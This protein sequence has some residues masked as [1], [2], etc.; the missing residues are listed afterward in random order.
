[1]A[2]GR[3]V[4]PLLDW[5]AIEALPEYRELEDSRRRFAWR[6]GA[7]GVG[8]GALYVVLAGVAPGLMGTEVLGSI[9]L[10]FVGGIGLIL[11]T[12]AITFAYMRRSDRVWGPMEEQVRRHAHAAQRSRFSR[13]GEP[14]EAP[15]PE[16]SR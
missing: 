3:G 11:M 9:S 5:A 13:E 14:A 15:A 4:E 16:V 1:V 12:W 2:D 6:A 10:G 7:I 8:L